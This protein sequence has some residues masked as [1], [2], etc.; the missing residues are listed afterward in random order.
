MQPPGQLA[1][2]AREVVLGT[3][4][5]DVVA[6]GQCAAQLSRVDFRPR[7]VPG[8]EVVNRMKDPQRQIIVAGRGW[9]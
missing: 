2:R 5:G 4:D 9:V 1:V 8:Q 3:D 6:R 7:P